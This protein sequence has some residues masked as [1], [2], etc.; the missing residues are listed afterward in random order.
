VD[1]IIHHYHQVCWPT[2]RVPPDAL[3]ALQEKILRIVTV[4][5]EL[6]PEHEAAL[7]ELW[8]GESR[9]ALFILNSVR[10][11]ELFGSRW[12]TLYNHALMD[13][14]CRVPLA[15]R[16]GRRLLIETSQRHL[17]T[18]PAARLADIPLAAS[19]P[20]TTGRSRPGRE[21]RDRVS[22]KTRARRA[23]EFVGLL[24]VVREGLGHRTDTPLVLEAWF[25]QGRD[26]HTFT[27]RQVLEQGGALK[28]LPPEFLHLIR[29]AL[30]RRLDLV[31]PLGVLAAMFLANVYAEMQP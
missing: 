27:L 2:A 22:W 30:N 15:M 9:Q 4:P 19:I 11:Y 23:L 18:G 12:W 28:A 10:A 24:E 26:P 3:A 16:I 21:H 1:E 6:R 7:L 14:L 17:Y 29:P 13:F 5:A 31:P 25:S 20:Q 8:E